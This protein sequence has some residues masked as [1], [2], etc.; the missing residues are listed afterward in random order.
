[1]QWNWQRKALYLD[2]TG[3][4]GDMNVRFG[5]TAR[6]RRDYPSLSLPHP[7]YILFY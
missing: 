5:K 2:D 7:V 3:V 1:M 6:R 4:S